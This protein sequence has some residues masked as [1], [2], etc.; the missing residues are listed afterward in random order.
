MEFNITKSHVSYTVYLW[1]IL[2]VVKIPAN[3]KANY[4]M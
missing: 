4:R 2:M 3:C 1:C